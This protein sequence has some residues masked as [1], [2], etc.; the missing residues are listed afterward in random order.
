MTLVSTQT[1]TGVTALT[2]SALTASNQF[3]IICRNLGV[4]IS[5]SGTMFVQIGTGVTPG[6][7]SSTYVTQEV[8]SQSATASGN[9]N[10]AN[11]GFLVSGGIS[12]STVYGYSFRGTMTNTNSSTLSVQ[13][14]GTYGGQ[15]TNLNTLQRSSVFSGTVV[16]GAPVTAIR[17]TIDGTI[18]FNGTCSLYSLAGS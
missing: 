7:I 6:W 1:G 12:N 15:S 5:A 3:E 2:W 10:T 16:S 4:N 9:Q 11:T 18:T 14:T 8:F 13:M 17:V